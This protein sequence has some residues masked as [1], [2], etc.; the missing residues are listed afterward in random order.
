MQLLFVAASKQLK[1]NYD[2]TGHKLNTY[3]GHSWIHLI[4][5]LINHKQFQQAIVGDTTPEK[6]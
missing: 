1:V 3:L 2:E 6:N 4:N 5:Y